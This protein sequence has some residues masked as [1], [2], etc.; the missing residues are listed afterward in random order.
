MEYLRCTFGPRLRSSNMSQPEPAYVP[1]KWE[2]WGDNLVLGTSS[3]AWALLTSLPILLLLVLRLLWQLRWKDDTYLSIVTI[4]HTSA[5]SRLV[6]FLGFLR[7][8]GQV[9]RGIGRTGSTEYIKWHQLYRGAGSGQDDMR[10]QLQLSDWEPR[11]IDYIANRSAPGQPRKFLPPAAVTIPPG[12][13]GVA[14]RVPGISNQ[15]AKTLARRLIYPGSVFFLQRQMQPFLLQG[16]GQLV[17]QHC[18][19]FCVKSRAGNTIDCMLCDRRGRSSVGERLFITSEGNASF[20]GESV[21]S[22]AFFLCISNLLMSCVPL[23]R[24]RRQ[25]WAI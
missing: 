2:R 19:R 16:R 11:P 21:T 3:A 22:R 4:V 1:P 5:L 23:T 24:C 20:Y 12:W 10:R 15:I 7:I 13:Q 25:R 6:Y 18:Q 17:Q 14:L 8:S 9:M